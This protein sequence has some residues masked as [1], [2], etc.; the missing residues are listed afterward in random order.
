[1]RPHGSDRRYTERVYDRCPVGPERGL[2]LTGNGRRSSY[3]SI[4]QVRMTNTYIEPG[5]SS[6]E[7]M[8][9]RMGDGLP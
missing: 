9:E 2:P 1:M 6:F 5:D 3:R 4:P 7:E 8:M